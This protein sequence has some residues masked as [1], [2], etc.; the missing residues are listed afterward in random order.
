[1]IVAQVCSPIIY[2]RVSLKLDYEE[3]YIPSPSFQSA[4]RAQESLHG[5]I[6]R[7]NLT[8]QDNLT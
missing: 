6:Q 4:L 1:M 3:I 7:E 2:R 5:L 8:N